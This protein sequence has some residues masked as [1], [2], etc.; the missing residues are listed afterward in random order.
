M[1]KK[2]QTK[3]HTFIHTEYYFYNRCL[4][5]EHMDRIYTIAHRGK[6]TAGNWQNYKPQSV[7]FTPLHTIHD[8]PPHPHTG[9]LFNVKPICIYNTFTGSHNVLI[10]TNQQYYTPMYNNS[11][12]GRCCVEVWTRILL[13]NNPNMGHVV[14]THTNHTHTFTFSAKRITNQQTNKQK[15]NHPFESNETKVI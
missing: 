13:H 14:N 8:P 6:K 5:N 15:H 3:K 12:A 1:I 11:G 7:G 9:I 4:D 10:Q 2:K